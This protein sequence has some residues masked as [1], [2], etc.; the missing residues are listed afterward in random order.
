MKS[1]NYFI[2]VLLL[3]SFTTLSSFSLVDNEKNTYWKVLYESSDL[4]IKYKY[5]ECHM[6][7]DGIHK[8]QVFLQFVNRRGED[9]KVDYDKEL[10]YNDRC[11]TCDS[12]GNENHQ[13]LVLKAGETAEGSC[14]NHRNKAYNIVSKVLAPGAKSV[15]TDFKLNQIKIS[16][17][18]SAE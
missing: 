1:A 16:T 11:T 9:I 8:E 12:D 15:L 10:W 7:A 17:L 6:P 18:N 5:G 14:D 13:S 3:S 4:M 2:W